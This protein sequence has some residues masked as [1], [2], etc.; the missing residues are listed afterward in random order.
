MVELTASNPSHQM[1]ATS[2]GSAPEMSLALAALLVRPP[3]FGWWAEF[4]DAEHEVAYREAEVHH[5]LCARTL[6]VCAADTLLFGGSFVARIAETGGS[7]DG[8][9]LVALAMFG[10]YA[11][12]SGVTYAALRRRARLVVAELA[13]GAVLVA[14][15]TAST[16]FTHDPA[17]EQAAVHLDA[18]LWFPSSHAAV[19]MILLSRF[20][21]VGVFTPTRPRLFAAVLALNWLAF[22]C[23]DVL[24]SDLR[25]QEVLMLLLAVLVMST[26]L[27]AVNLQLALIHRGRYW[28]IRESA[29]ALVERE[30]LIRDE[31][32]TAL[33]LAAVAEERRAR[34]KLIRMV[35]HDLRSPLLSISNIAAVL[36]RMDTST[37]LSEPIVAKCCTSLGTC[38]ALTQS[39]ISD[40]LDFERID[41]GRLVL[42]PAP[43][44]VRDLLAASQATF[45]VRRAARL[46]RAGRADRAD[47]ARAAP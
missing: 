40:M 47:R 17:R 1:R 9:G 23:G 25:L 34:S 15:P 21:F 5:T 14:T 16:F 13:F 18:P 7:L 33:R 42:L 36:A 29:L 3:R 27:V 31:T 37:P 24:V 20:M 19:H 28:F 30:R 8:F 32:R 44:R 41:S 11:L 12:V 2:A 45:E 39:I 43:F 10:L 26:L 22:L 35:M 4:A 46:R 38:A 6:I